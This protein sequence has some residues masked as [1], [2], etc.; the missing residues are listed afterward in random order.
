MNRKLVLAFLAACALLP[1]CAAAG[2]TAARITIRPVMPMLVDNPVM[3]GHCATGGAQIAG[4]VE[5]TSAL[6]YRGLLVDSA[7]VDVDASAGAGQ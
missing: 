3:R 2:A 5:I 6:C 1:G 4:A 7:I